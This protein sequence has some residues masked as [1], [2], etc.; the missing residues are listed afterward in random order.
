MLRRNRLLLGCL[1]A[2]AAGTSAFVGEMT[3]RRAAL[4]PRLGN[5]S[6]SGRWSQLRASTIEEDEKT[7]FP[8]AENSVLGNLVPDISQ[9]TLG[10][11]V[12]LSVPVVWGTYVPVVR[13]LYDFDPPIPGF[14][15]SFAYFTVA[16][17]SSL[18]L[19]ASQYSKNNDSSTPNNSSPFPPLPITAGAEL[20]TYL[21]LGNC[22]Q[23]MGLRSVPADKA[24]FLVQCTWC[25]TCVRSRI[26]IGPN[27]HLFGS[28][29]RLCAPRPSRPV[30]QLPLH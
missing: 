15:F 4:V 14:L 18:A 16:S 26:L 23:V 11:M 1:A 21:F 3:H 20:G 7:F 6:T 25:T 2:S 19:V 12:L 30:G 29:H 13:S 9:E 8:F 5:R 24:G 17:L 10:L 27:S 22:L 28:N